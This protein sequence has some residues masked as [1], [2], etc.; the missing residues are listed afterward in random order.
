MDDSL[1]NN[2]PYY[3]WWESAITYLIRCDDAHH[4]ALCKKEGAV[5]NRK[6]K[7][8]E[9]GHEAVT[10]IGIDRQRHRLGSPSLK[11]DAGN[12]STNTI[13]Y[14]PKGTAFKSGG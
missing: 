13:C 6:A 14:M 5:W 11:G 8:K 10:T 7:C 12:I 2:D 1:H 4:A 9:P 3:D